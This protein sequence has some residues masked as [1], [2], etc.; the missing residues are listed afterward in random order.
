MRE[1]VKRDMGLQVVQK[2]E[3]HELGGEERRSHK[4]EPTAL[5]DSVEWSAPETVSS[6]EMWL[7]GLV[8]NRSMAF[9]CTVIM[10]SFFH[11]V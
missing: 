1:T 4:D 9:F 11:L 3:V 7:A 8:E 5:I 2:T 6:I 10:P